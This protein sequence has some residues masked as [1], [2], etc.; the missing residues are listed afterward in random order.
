MR[1]NI[2]YQNNNFNRNKKLKNLFTKSINIDGSLYWFKIII[3][4]VI[5]K[6]E[7]FLFYTIYC[8][9]FINRKLK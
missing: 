2:I 6:N 3:N 1:I 7:I 5:T 4:S 8:Y 9:G